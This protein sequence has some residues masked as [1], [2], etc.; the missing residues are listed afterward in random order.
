MFTFFFFLPAKPRI[1]T[2]F[3]S[4]PRVSCLNHQVFFALFCSFKSFSSFSNQVEKKVKPYIF[5]LLDL[6]KGFFFLRTKKKV[7][8]FSIKYSQ[9]PPF[10]FRTSCHREGCHFFFLLL[11]RPLAPSLQE[12]QCVKSQENILLFPTR[13]A[14]FRPSDRGKVTT[15]FWPSWNGRKRLWMSL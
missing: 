9:R 2:L 1:I 14:A 6:G 7:W 4:S 11:L 13:L 15:A 3:L 8:R 5:Y 10:P 12:W